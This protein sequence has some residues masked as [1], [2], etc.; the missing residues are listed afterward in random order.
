[1]QVTGNSHLANVNVLYFQ[2]YFPVLI[3]SK[4]SCQILSL[5]DG[6]YDVFNHALC[7]FVLVKF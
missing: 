2:L 4:I 6:D 3:D 1:M 5:D 7:S